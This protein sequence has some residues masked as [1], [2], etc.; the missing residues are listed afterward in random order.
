MM[1]NGEMPV[2][3]ATT[4]AQL[5]ELVA[6][7]SSAD[8]ISLDTESNSRHRYPEEL[9]MV[10]IAAGGKIYIIDTIKLTNIDIL[11]TVLAN[12]AQVKVIH[13]ASYDVRCLDRHHGLRLGGIFDTSIAARFLGITQISLAALIESTLG[14]KIAKNTRLQQSDWGKRPLTVE[15]LEYA[16]DDVRYLA[17]IRDILESKLQAIDRLHWVTEEFRRLEEMRYVPPDKENAFR[18]VKGARHLDGRSLAILKSVYS[19]R[20]A[21]AVREHRPP[22]FILP[23]ETMLDLASRPGQDLSYVFGSSEY[24]KRVLGRGL[25]EAIR[26]GEKGSPVEIMPNDL[27]ER[28]T[29]AEFERLNRLKSWRISLGAKLNLDPSLCWPRESIEAIAKAPGELE[30]SLNSGAVRQWQ[31][32]EFGTALRDYVRSIS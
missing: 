2:E 29:A 3:I 1:S 5:Q 12:R 21:A 19:F 13:D 17:G 27:F 25:P 23:D 10:Q 28:P 30:A 32:V 6:R 31:R 4:P 26:E 22:Y 11:G 24:R 14:M 15:A 16:S 20:E 18:Y 8:V 9:C 7:I